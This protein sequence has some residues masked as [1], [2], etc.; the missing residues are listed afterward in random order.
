MQAIVL[1]AAGGP[2][3]GPLCQASPKGMIPFMG[4]PLLAWVV[5]WLERHDSRDVTINLRQRPYPV[6]AYFHHNPPAQA[7]VK[8]RLEN[9]RLGTAGAVKRMA[10]PRRETM[11]VCMGDLITA[12]D[13]DAAFA[14][15]KAKNSLVTLV[16]VPG[17][18]AAQ[19]GRAVVD[20]EGRLVSFEEGSTDQTRLASAG[21]YLIEPD[22][23]VH[24]SGENCD[25]GRDF[26]PDLLAKNLPVYGYETLDY[27]MDAG[28]PGGYMQALTDALHGRIPGVKPSGVEVKPGV[29]VEP[30]A[31]VH[32]K[33]K[34]NAPCW[35]GAGARVTMEAKVGPVAA[36]EGQAELARGAA[37]VAGAVFP[38]AYVGRATTWEGT[39]LYPDGS[40]DLGTWPAVAQASCDPDVLGTTWREPLADRLHTL[41][42]QTVAFLGLL[43]IAPLLLLLILAI[44]LD[45]PGPAF[46]TQLRVGRDRRP[47]RHGLPR[48][49]IFECFK[50][51]TMHVDADSKVKE[52]MAQNQYGNS[53]FFKLEND[54]R[55]TRVGNFLRKTSLDELPQ[56]IN[57]LRG[58]MR[59]VGNRPLPVYE[60][61][62]L[63]EDWQRTRFLAPAGITGLWQISG[64]SDLSEKERLAL[65]AY[66][67]VTRTFA[68]DLG[69]LFKTFPALLLR[70]GAK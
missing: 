61:E 5:Q 41:F 51:R 26:F 29:W 14:F 44:K 45:S 1:A 12:V 47:Y 58:E 59:L 31:V 66:Y 49:E 10:G 28:Q 15:H 23:L 18:R 35:I 3:F 48:G 36:V 68:G 25:F 38:G 20:E 60:A 50:F 64:R 13:L 11:V 8:F 37:V 62:A 24:V 9:E 43:A 40:I 19:A 63:H 46:Y 6:E 33:A 39:L 32:P 55:I 27:W 4:Q 17:A 2:E 30:G 53:A 70:R 57:V 21:I 67:T 22:A 69:I 42:D 34:L 56:L 54:P 52:L 16:L 65:D 7:R